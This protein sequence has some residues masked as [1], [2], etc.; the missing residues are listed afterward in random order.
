M[1]N[2]LYNEQNNIGSCLLFHKKLIKTTIGSKKTKTK[3]K[4]LNPLSTIVAVQNQG[5]DFPRLGTRYID[6]FAIIFYRR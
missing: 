1:N 2:I 4:R 5:K 6:E 3:M